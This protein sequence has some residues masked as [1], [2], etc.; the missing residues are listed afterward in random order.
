M[1]GDGPGGQEQCHQ[2]R[3]T[4]K[5][6]RAC[7]RGKRLA[8]GCGQG[9]DL[10]VLLGILQKGPAGGPGDTESYGS[11]EAQGPQPRSTLSL[12]SR[13]APGTGLPSDAREMSKTPYQLPASD[14]RWRGFHQQVTVSRRTFEQA[15]AGGKGTSHAESE[16]GWQTGGSVSGLGRGTATHVWGA[17]QGEQ[18]G[19]PRVWRRESSKSQIP[20]NPFRICS[21]QC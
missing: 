9:A 8:W 18:L 10:G 11:K 12:S 20:H 2:E 21:E 1:E 16:C 3:G 4:E 17:G 14:S 15:A 13:S 7:G 19:V 5:A 6:K